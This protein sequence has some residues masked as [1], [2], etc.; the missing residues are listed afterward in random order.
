MLCMPTPG[1][2]SLLFLCPQSVQT[3]VHTLQAQEEVDRVLGSRDKPTMGEM[4]CCA[5]AVHAEHMCLRRRPC[6]RPAPLR[7]LLHALRFRHLVDLHAHRI[8]ALAAPLHAEDYM[9]LKYVMR[10][11]NESM[12]LYPHPPVLLRRA[13]VEDELPGERGIELGVDGTAWAWGGERAVTGG[14]CTRP[15]LLPPCARG[16]SA[17]VREAC[18]LGGGDAALVQTGG[19][20]AWAGQRA[21]CWLRPARAAA[22]RRAAAQPQ[23]AS[24]SAP[25]RS[26]GCE[27]PACR[28]GAASAVPWSASLCSFAHHTHAMPSA[29]GFTVPAGQDVMI[30]VYN[31]HRSPAGKALGCGPRQHETERQGRASTTTCLVPY[32]AAYP[33]AGLLP[34]CRPAA[35]PCA[36]CTA[37]H[38][39]ATPRFKH[40]SPSLCRRLLQCGTGRTNSCRSGSPWTAPP[41][42]SRTQTTSIFPSGRGVGG[43]LEW[44]S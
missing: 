40:Q 18:S 44:K 6:W 11:V 14:R 4:A 20:F 38:P 42:T 28:S 43:R 29:G 17:S 41:P 30:S 26:A 3:F 9:N 24:C 33:A 32:T 15:R 21:T 2:P 36:A 22:P 13:L 34:A 23:P 25:Q 27:A 16:T 12:R 39:S 37:V 7:W 19:R 8:A 10:C 5:S 1:V 31:I 35:Y